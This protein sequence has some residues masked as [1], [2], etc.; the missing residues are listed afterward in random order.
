MNQY[1]LTAFE[2]NGQKLTDEI[3]TAEND[4]EAKESGEHLLQEKKLQE[5]THRL[6][7]SS[8]KLLLFHS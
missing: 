2:T 5:K 7:S 1:V 4:N 3:I 6:T 8:G